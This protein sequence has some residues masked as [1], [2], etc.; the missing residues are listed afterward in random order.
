MAYVDAPQ[1]IDQELID[2]CAQIQ[3]GHRHQTKH[4]NGQDLDGVKLKPW[5]DD[6]VQ[7]H[8]RHLESRLGQIRIEDHNELKFIGT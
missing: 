1:L 2:E 3:F 6:D 7:E 5:L 4:R 8:I